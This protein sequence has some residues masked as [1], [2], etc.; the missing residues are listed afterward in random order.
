[1]TI[2]YNAHVPFV[3]AFLLFAAILACVH[4]RRR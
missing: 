3:T 1:M 2:L 4:W